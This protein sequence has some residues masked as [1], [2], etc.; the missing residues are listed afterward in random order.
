MLVG[1]IVYIKSGQHIP[2]DLV[3]LLT[4]K[5]NQC[6]IETAQL[7]GE[8]NLKLRK[9]PVE[10]ADLT[11]KDIA[12]LKGSIKCEVPTPNLYS[13]KGKLKVT[14]AE[15]VECP[16]K[17]P[18]GP[19]NLLLKNSK[20]MNTKWAVGIIVYAGPE[21]KL[22]LNLK[23]P[24]SKMS[25]LDR[26]LNIYVMVILIF[27][28]LLC[29]APA[30]YA[31]R[32]FR[33]TALKSWY[34]VDDSDS[35]SATVSPLIF[36]IQSFFSYFALLSNFLPLS[37]VVSLEMIKVAQAIFITWDNRMRS[38]GNG[39]KVKTSS[40][41][42]DLGLV[43]YIFSD[44]TG[45]LTENVMKMKKV[46]VYGKI[47]RHK[48]MVKMA[49]KEESSGEN[50]ED[51]MKKFK[52]FFTIV[53]M[54]H[55]VVAEENDET[56]EL[57][58]KSVSPDEEA[59]VKGASKYGFKF[60]SRDSKGV[61]KLTI[62]GEETEMTVLN[63]L[64]FTSDRRR[65]SVIVKIED[66]IEMWTKGADS[67]VMSLLKE[68]DETNNEL[69]SICKKN[70]SKF[71]RGGLRTLIVAKRELTQEEYDSF[72]EKYSEAAA[73]IEDR[74]EKID[75]ICN[76]IEKD[77]VL[78]GVTAI[79]DKLQ[80]HVPE[81]IDYLMRMNIKVWMITG[82]QMD[83]A[84]NIG[85]STKL[86]DPD[87]IL[88]KINGDSKEECK[89]ML[90]KLTSEH[91]SKGKNKKKK[92]TNYRQE[93]KELSIIIDGK[94]LSYVLDSE[95]LP[96]FLE[97]S[98]VCR[99]VICCRV[100]PLQKA[101]VVKSVKDYT[102]SV[103]LAIG[104]GA[105]DVSMIQEAHVGVGIFGREGTHAARSSDYAIRQFCHIQRLLAIHGRYAMV[106]SAGVIY[107]SFYK[108]MMTF[109]AQIWFS[110]FTG[111]SSQSVYDDW[112]VASFN[113]IVTALP[114]IIYGVF[115]KDVSEKIIN[116]S[117]E[118]YSRT[119]SYS[120]F[121]LK[122]LVTWMAAACFHSIVIFCSCYMVLGPR[123]V[124]D[125]GGDTASFAVFS[126]SLFTAS[127]VMVFVKITLETRYWTIVTFSIY[128]ISFASYFLLLLGESALPGLFPEQYNI[129]QKIFS[130][131][132]TYLL[133]LLAAW[134]CVIPDM[135]LKYIDE[136]RAPEGWQRLLK[137]Y[138]QAKKEGNASEMIADDPWEVYEGETRPLLGNRSDIDPESCLSGD[139]ELNHNQVDSQDESEE[140]EHSDS[141]GC[142]YCDL[143]SEDD[144]VETNRNRSHLLP[145]KW[146][147]FSSRRR[148]TRS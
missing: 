30:V 56:H 138:S 27:Q 121:T 109:S 146:F 38:E 91:V 102:K 95:L 84:I 59:L 25:Q 117:P 43:E 89:T 61:S 81:A 40:L 118:V 92:K 147:F 112:M 15:G 67:V 41:N 6:Y 10:F 76:E 19:D 142:E 73:S 134:V 33:D 7:D 1:D 23:S 87:H 39:A 3:C 133:T 24:P 72:N 35:S 103:C 62:Q 60:N 132:S 54:C 122:K 16:A 78:V 106:R 139:E 50:S 77:F 126:N 82:D 125:S 5:Q 47:Y 8:T 98:T 20:L 69:K 124:V 86:I 46:S 58:Y 136:E 144:S 105:N 52:E 115:E 21:T 130:L 85:Y 127:I 64:E 93:S 99:S 129:F 131:P 12:K 83:T 113:T 108:N 32:F 48:E 17:I 29:I 2:A 22:S 45:T 100:T 88:G 90:E 143:D 114:P 57:E 36:G 135:V 53:S 128:L 9:S 137:E 18:L 96:L 145:W 80:H 94:N 116:K 63:T 110:F 148:H 66:R 120:V 141:D 70:V 44:K 49:E 71:S 28:I 34:L 104:D 68:S 51:D 97:L 14:E 140:S 65:M 13:F 37:L 42:D 107:Y 4:S 31:G 74:E 55:N 119:Q 123:S 26:R 75:E 11:L 101:M 111:W 79:E